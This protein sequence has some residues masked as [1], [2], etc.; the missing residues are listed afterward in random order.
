MRLRS[1]LVILVV[2]VLVPMLAF[3]GIVMVMLGRQQR[4]AA[5]RGAIETA[6]ALMNALDESLKSTMTTLDALASAPAL[7]TGD[8]RT[9]DALVRRILPTQPD[10]LDIIL[11]SADSRTLVDTQFPFGTASRLASEPASVRETIDTRRPV[12]GYVARGPAGRYAVPVRVPV[13]RRGEVVAVLTAVVKPESFLAVLQRQRVPP[14]WVIGAF[15]RRKNIVARTRGLADFLGRPVSPEFVALL[16][17]GGAEGWASTHTL[18][19]DPVY[20]AYARSEISG[21]GIGIGIP[22][23]AVDAPLRRSL[24]VTAAGGLA[25]AVLAL[26]LALLIGRRITMSMAEL[27]GA[28]RRFGE[29]APMRADAP[30]R[31]REL[32]EVRRA[33]VGAAD[34]V[35]ERAAEAAAAARAKDEFLAILSHE[36]R[37]PLN[38]VYGW[39]R[40]LQRSSFSESQ[41]ARALEVI[42]RQSNAQLQLIDDLLDVSR[43]VSGKMRVDVRPV[44]LV[45]VIEQALDAVRPA[46]EAKAIRLDSRLNPQI[47]PVMGDAARLQQ[48]VWNLLMNG[49]KFTPAGG[50]VRIRLER[51]ES[52]VTIVVSDTGSGIPA[53]TLSFVFEP[54]RQADSSSTREHGGLGLGLALVRHLVELHGGTVRAQS[55]GAGRGATFIVQ[56]PLALTRT[57]LPSPTS[58]GDL[59]SAP[60]A[61]LNGLRVLVVDDDRDAGDLADAILT[62]AG[63]AVRVATSASDALEVIAAWQ[64]DVL[65]SDIGMPGDDGYAFIRSVRA[66]DSAAGGRTPA[67]ALTAYGRT[68]DRAASL[69]AGYD[70][71]VPKPVDPGELTAIVASVAQRGRG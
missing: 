25:F 12:V 39:A 58:G 22:V 42:V 1:V 57:A 2:A 14:Q 24:L 69:S 38:A 40:M 50:N 7:E 55:E 3:T 61:R 30:A 29:G 13:V 45:A 44:D 6:R 17:R 26:A 33:F 48:V 60:G 67:V 46:A 54:F 8:L 9:F 34:L 5:E 49:V 31:V 16:D 28:A 37:T 18:E 20:T 59:T 53:D 15:D 10:W 65:V 47:G 70:M 64:P 68:E 19:G 43:V 52:H 63:A 71:H 32:D 66:L 23:D 4:A 36:L 11:L 21:W 41:R 62:G 56:L 35:R 51:S 27:T